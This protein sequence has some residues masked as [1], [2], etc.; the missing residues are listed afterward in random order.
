MRMQPRADNEHNEG[1]VRLDLLILFS[2]KV[3]WPDS[4]RNIL[5]SLDKQQ[6]NSWICMLW[7]YSLELKQYICFQ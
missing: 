4:G 5:E 7:D 2:V 1:V 3:N 6:I